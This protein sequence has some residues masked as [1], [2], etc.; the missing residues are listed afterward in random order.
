MNELERLIYELKQRSENDP[1]PRWKVAM[2]LGKCDRR[3][4]EALQIM[5]HHGM[6]VF[7]SK[8]GGYYWAD[9]DE[10]EAALR[11]Y[12]QYGITILSDCYRI[13][14]GIQ[15]GGLPGQLDLDALLREDATDEAATPS[16]TN[17]S[18]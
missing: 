1:L 18:L 15:D 12:E 14:R 4:R 13:R 16:N 6:P 11:H 9:G 17:T 8:K 10:L 7:P 2:I 5:R 3:A